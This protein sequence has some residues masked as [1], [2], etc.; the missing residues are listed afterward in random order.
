M[1]TQSMTRALNNEN[2]AA[3]LYNQF[4]STI[5]IYKTVKFSEEKYL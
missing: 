2:K 4:L 1:Q 3:I 5:I